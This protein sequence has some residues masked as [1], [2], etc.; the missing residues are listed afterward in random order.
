M[1]ARKVGNVR[2]VVRSNRYNTRNRGDQDDYENI[3]AFNSEDQEQS[4]AVDMAAVDDD[5]LQQA[6]ATHG[7]AMYV[8]KHLFLH[9]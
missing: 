7:R 8:D 5:M 6:L 2:S 4:V 9:R 3:V 1:A